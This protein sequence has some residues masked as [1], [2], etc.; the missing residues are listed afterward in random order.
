MTDNKTNVPSKEELNSVI[1]A[2]VIKSVE[3]GNCR[4]E[5]TARELKQLWRSFFD[6]DYI[7][8]EKLRFLQ[9]RQERLERRAALEA[10]LRKDR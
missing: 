9:E 5:Q 6:E 3:A 8:R 7:K 1:W 4:P 10:E 2:T